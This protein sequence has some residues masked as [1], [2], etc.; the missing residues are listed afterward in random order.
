MKIYWK[1][2]FRE[3]VKFNL[4]LLVVIIVLVAGVF[5]IDFIENWF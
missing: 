5:A 3:I 4:I 1:E 2:L